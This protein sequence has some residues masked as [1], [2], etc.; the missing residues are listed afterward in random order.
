MWLI[1]RKCMGVFLAL[2]FISFLVFV[3]F[4]IIPGDPALLR[5]GQDA[6]AESVAALRA[7]MGLDRPML[8]RYAAWAGGF[9]S[10]ELG[11]S[12]AHGVPVWDL[13]AVR[14]PI[15]FALIS[16]S[17]M[18]NILLAVPLGFVGARLGKRR[19]MFSLG[20]MLAQFGM[21][22]P[23]LFLGLMFTFLF[24]FTLRLFTPSAF[25]ARD[26]DVF[27]FWAYLFVPALAIALPKVAMTVRFIQNAVQDEVQRAYV[28]TAKSRGCSP[29][30]ILFAHVLPN[31]SAPT[32]SFL[33]LSLIMIVTD[34]FVIEQLF[35]IP[36]AGRLFIAAIGA[37]DYPVVQS[38]VVL[39][40]AFVIVIHACID[41]LIKA[42]DPRIHNG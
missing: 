16:M 21:A 32:L 25:V 28:R 13:I 37:R 8:V 29:R 10:G 40:A 15:S 12:Y 4:E 26:E 19:R 42:I 27:G 33:G 35:T 3:A 39:I 34:T 38:F 9:M 6:T 18:L 24:G 14:L 17:F 41:L 11:V 22:I 7:E 2:F 23:P 1:L 30:R 5:L 31:V 20:E 36:G